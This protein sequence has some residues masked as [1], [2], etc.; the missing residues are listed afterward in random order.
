MIASKHL[1]K[2]IVNEKKIIC[3]NEIANK[4]SNFFVKIGLK[5][6]EKLQPAKYSS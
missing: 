3:K 1:E 4:F 5:L 6:A 2:C